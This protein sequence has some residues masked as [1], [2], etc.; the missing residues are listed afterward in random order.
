ME[1]TV[2]ALAVACIRYISLLDQLRQALEAT[3]TRKRKV[4]LY[5]S[6][7]VQLSFA[8]A[9]YVFSLLFFIRYVESSAVKLHKIISF[10][11][12]YLSYKEKLPSRHQ[13]WY[14]PRELSRAALQHRLSVA[15]QAQWGSTAAQAQ[16]S[17]T[18]SVWQHRLSGAAL[19][20]RLSG[21]AQAQ[22]SSTA[23]QAQWG[24]TGSVGQHCSTGSVGQHRLS[25]AAQAQWGST[26]SVGQHRLSGAAQAQWGSTAG[27]VG[28]VCM[29]M[30]MY[31]VYTCTV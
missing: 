3:A 1:V 4:A 19:Q 26:G 13:T 20:H 8:A 7:F 9:E 5:L 10:Y 12:C 24:S 15:A 6:H 29:S 28:Q 2:V 16:W 14:I 17:S 31:S 27:S 30:I 21:A 23:A 22:W 18:G 11:T 25:V